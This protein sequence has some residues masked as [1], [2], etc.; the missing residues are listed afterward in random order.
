VIVDP[1]NLRDKIRELEKLL[2]SERSKGKAMDEE[3]N[4]LKQ[5]AKKLQEGIDR[6]R[7]LCEECD[8]LMKTDFSNAST[9]EAYTK[10]FE[11]LEDEVQHL[12]D[13]N[14]ELV[15]ELE[16]KGKTLSEMCSQ[17]DALGKEN[18]TL[19]EKYKDALQGKI[20]INL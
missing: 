14:K 10:K 1:T 20:E 9:A 11:D 5:E 3:I 12:K 18:N 8:I 2:S 15:D 4:N 17:S 13:R 16:E 6:A 7:R 19:A